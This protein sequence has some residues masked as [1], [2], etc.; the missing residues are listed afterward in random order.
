ML[1]LTAMTGLSA[2][3]IR[4]TQKEDTTR[5]KELEE[6]VITATRTERKLGNVAVPVQVITDRMI[7]QSGS[8]RINDILQEQTGVAITSAGATTSAGGGVFGN[9]IQLQGLSPDYT[10]IL[11]DGEPLIGRQGG[12]LDLTR[13]ATGNIKKIEIVK[14][15]SSSLYGSEAMG[16]VVNIIT[17][18]PSQDQL[19]TTLRYGRFNTS[20]ANLTVSL[21]RD[22]WRLQVFG[23]RNQ[24]NG[25]DLDKNAEGKTVDP[26]INY[27]GQVRMIYQPTAK[28]KVSVS[29][30]YY[31]EKQD[32]FF[33]FLTSLPVNILI[34][35]D[36]AG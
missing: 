11:I 21:K 10:L 9:G 36:L 1:A 5:A 24:S 13:I 25:F 19:R 18:Q 4:F 8:V 14:G 20:D 6:V 23:N 12:V 31:D 3:Q 27:T 29:A 15:P 30:R 17:E 22:K 34:S 2:Q 32:N 7:R 33:R 26:F 28:T 35:A 16:G